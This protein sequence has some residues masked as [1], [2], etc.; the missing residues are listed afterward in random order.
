MLPTN[1]QLQVGIC[2]CVRGGGR[3]IREHSSGAHHY[4]HIPSALVIVI[5]IM[6]VIIVTMVMII[7]IVMVLDGVMESLKIP[8]HDL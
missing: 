5:T 2:D 6:I 8:T 7:I 3:T 1:T 4:H